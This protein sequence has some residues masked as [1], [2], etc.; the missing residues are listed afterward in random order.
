[1]S[2]PSIQSIQSVQSIIKTTGFT[3]YWIGIHSL[4][5]MFIKHKYSNK[6]SRPLTRLLASRCTSMLHA[7]GT[8]C[9]CSYIL[10]TEPHWTLLNSPLQTLLAQTS[11]SYFIYDTLYMSLFEPDILFF[12]HHLGGA[13]LSGMVAYTGLGGYY[14]VLGILLGE[15][16][17][18]LQLTWE[19][20]RR[21][22]RKDLYKKLTPYY[23]YTFLTL[24]VGVIPLFIPIL[25]KHASKQENLSVTYKMCLY[26]LMIGLTVGSWPWCWALWNGYK[27]FLKKQ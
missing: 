14:W 27:R 20:S 2:D 12:L 13:A 4:T 10:L 25:I 26:T 19:V 18:P 15:I 5:H 7:C 11:L 17:N 9:M 1:M 16:S 23:T 24:R 6:D 22:G 8:L 3:C 21:T